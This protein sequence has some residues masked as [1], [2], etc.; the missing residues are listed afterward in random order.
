M[1]WGDLTKRCSLSSVPKGKCLSLFPGPFAYIY[2]LVSIS[3]RSSVGCGPLPHQIRPL[4]EGEPPFQNTLRG[5]GMGEPTGMDHKGG[6]FKTPW[7]LVRERTI[8]TERPPLV[9]EI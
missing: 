8:P 9:D 7:P 3:T 2:A 4:A 6:P 1:T 5:L